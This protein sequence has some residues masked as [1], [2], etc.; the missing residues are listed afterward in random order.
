VLLPPPPPPPQQE[1]GNKNL[2]HLNRKSEADRRKTNVGRQVPFMDINHLVTDGFYYT[3]RSD[4]VRSAFCELE[5]GHWKKGEDEFKNPQNWSPCCG[6]LKVLFVRNIP[7]GSDISL[8]SQG[9]GCSYD[10]CGSYKEIT[11]NTYFKG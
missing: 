4:V 9:T 2:Q 8:P 10:V 11:T 7:I 3:N 6:I 5:V 1:P